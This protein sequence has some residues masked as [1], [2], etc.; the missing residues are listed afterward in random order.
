M[1]IS[2][3]L[4]GEID[5]EYTDGSEKDVIKTKYVSRSGVAGKEDV[6]EITKNKRGDVISSKYTGFENNASVT[7]IYTNEYD[8]RNRIS[9][10]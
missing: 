3:F 10:N 4:Y 7:E 6:F 2:C 5:T 9:T 1:Y 8:N